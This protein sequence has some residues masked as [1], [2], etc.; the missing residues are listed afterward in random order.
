MRGGRYNAAPEHA[1]S[2]TYLRINEIEKMRKYL[3]LLHE[4]I[5]G[6]ERRLLRVERTAFV[7]RV[8]SEEMAV[9]LFGVRQRREERRRAIRVRTN[10][11]WWKS[12]CKDT[13]CVT[14]A[15]DHHD[16][17]AYASGRRPH[18]L[19]KPTPGRPTA[20]QTHG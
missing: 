9:V 4:P 16:R 20:G 2:C 17:D 5:V 14:K 10:S 3:A 7:G 18:G 19:A 15:R 8:C 13:T 1:I 11:G 6:N 12:L